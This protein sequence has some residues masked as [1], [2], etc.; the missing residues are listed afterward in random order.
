MKVIYISISI[1]TSISI[2]TAGVVGGNSAHER[3]RKC[4]TIH[5]EVYGFPENTCNV[6]LQ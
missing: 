2:G 1:S 3:A 4:L 5:I 6:G